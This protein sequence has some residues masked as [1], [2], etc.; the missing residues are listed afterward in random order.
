MNLESINWVDVVLGGAIIISAL[1]GIARGL[2]KEVLSLLSWVVAIWVAWKFADMVA[3]KYIRGFIDDPTISYL[4]AFGGL[5]LVT[6]F[7]LGL[8][9]MLISSFLASSG[10]GGI[11]RMLGMVFGLL[12]GLIIAAILVFVGKFVP[13]VT[14]MAAWKDSKLQ[15][16]FSAMAEWGIN[17]LPDNIQKLLNDTTTQAESI[18]ILSSPAQAAS[19]DADARGPVARPATSAEAQASQRQQTQN[20]AEIGN[21]TA[22][23][24]T[25]ESAQPAQQDTAPIVLESTQ[26]Q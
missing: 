22:P 15:P 4:A 13:P 5:F 12:R 25:L 20:I 2:I 1:V 26:G 3:E 9:N 10:L 19:T 6:L 8:F 17:K 24:I 23:A 7:A 21:N 16:T 14:D 18:G 11:D